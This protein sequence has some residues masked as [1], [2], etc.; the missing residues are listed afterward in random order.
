LVV[1]NRFVAAEATVA[2]KAQPGPLVIRNPFVG[3][4]VEQ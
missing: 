1:R 3:E 4:A 2:A